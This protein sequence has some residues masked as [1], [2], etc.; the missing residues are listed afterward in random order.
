MDKIDRRKF[1]LGSVSA[2]SLPLMAFSEVQAQ[3][4]FQFIIPNY[5][6][7][8]AVGETIPL[9]IFTR[10]Q[11]PRLRVIFK[12][13]GQ[14]IGVTTGY[15]YKVNWIPTRTGNYT[16]T[17]EI[18]TQTNT[19]TIGTAAQVD[20]L[21]NS[22]G[23]I[24][25]RLYTLG[26]TISSYD[27]QALERIWGFPMNYIGT[28]NAP[29]TVTRIEA[30]VSATTNLFNDGRDIPFPNFRYITARFWNDGSTGFQNSP[31]FGNLSNVQLGNPNYGSTTIPIGTNSGGNKFYQ[32]G[33]SNLSIPLPASVPLGLSIQ[34]SINSPYDFTERINLAVSNLPVSNLLYAVKNSPNPPTIF[35]TS[36]TA[37][38]IWAI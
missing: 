6:T 1:L 31:I 22:I 2:I 14:Q 36:P 13:D 12:A 3:K 32:I 18:T 25:N 15:P 16:L 33:W 24:G 35:N 34:F 10:T 7:P 4:S 17:A 29:Q 28:L 38:R 8:F 5:E 27:S 21:Y 37:I 26:S 30:I 20:L 19:T 9:R 23:R 11:Y